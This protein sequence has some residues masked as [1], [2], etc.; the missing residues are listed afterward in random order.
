MCTACKSNSNNVLKNRLNSD[1][2]SLR[3]RL[4]S[5]KKKAYARYKLQKDSGDYAVY[6]QITLN[7]ANYSYCPE[8]YVV[9][10]Y[11]VEYGN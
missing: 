5:V 2:R 6:R 4:I 11:E 1:C 9:E 3:K 8:A 7:L 10:A